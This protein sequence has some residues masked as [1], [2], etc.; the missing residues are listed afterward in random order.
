M[1]KN[2][3]SE[4]WVMYLIG[5]FLLNIVMMTS[6]TIGTIGLGA[7]TKDLASCLLPS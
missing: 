7:G 4:F 2:I 5:L 3:I 6:F 1:Y